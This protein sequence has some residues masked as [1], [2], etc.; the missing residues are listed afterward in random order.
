MTSPSVIKRMLFAVLLAVFVAAPA[1]SQ[2][3]EELREENEVL[4]KQVRS[5]QKEL[6]DANARIARLERM[7]EQLQKRTVDLEPLEEPKVSIDESKP[8][9]SPRALFRAIVESHDKAM[10]EVEMDRPNSRQR[11]A[12][13]RA[14]E[15]WRAAAEREFKLPVEWH[16]RIVDDLLLDRFG[17]AKATLVAV[18]PETDAQL[19]DPFDVTLDA[20][21]VRRI[22]PIRERGDLD[23]LK[24]NG[25]VVPHIRVNLERQ[26]RGP[27]D[28]PKFIGSF[29]E[30]AMELQV[31]SL[32]PV[33]KPK[34][35]PAKREA[36]G[37]SENKDPTPNTRR[38][39]PDK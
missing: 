14:L 39:D 33:E 24:L 16:V 20:A 25:V 13:L 18:D 23:K 37:T 8:E 9:A 29:A 12:Y 34:A 30:Y 10:G 19:G 15:R 31:R 1:F 38:S 27:F 5:L 35:P 7:I 17:N 32:A 26:A 2:S 4:Q 3:A 28:S 11:T 6:D 21:M 22:V 36:Q